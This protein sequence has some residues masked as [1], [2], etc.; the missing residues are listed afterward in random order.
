M[1]SA[2]VYNTIDITYPVAGQDNDTQGFRDNFTNIQQGLATAA[3]EISTLQSNSIDKTANATFNGNVLDTVILKYAGSL[4]STVVATVSG[5]ATPGASDYSYRRYSLNA[6]TQ[7]KIDQ[8]PVPATTTG[9]L[10]SYYSVYLEL[11]TSATPIKKASF[12][13]GT[14]NTVLGAVSSNLYLGSGFGGQTY[15]NIAS[16][17]TTVIRMSSPDGGINVFVSVL[18]T[19]VKQ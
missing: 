5:S 7:F 8:F 15:I 11:T 13:L 2:I 14:V 17:T 10:G 1:T 19:F 16:G 4:S 18:D 9:G 12:G 6:D 3:S